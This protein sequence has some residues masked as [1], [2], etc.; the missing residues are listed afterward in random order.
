MKIIATGGWRHGKGTPNSVMGNHLAGGQGDG[1]EFG[2]CNRTN[3]EGNRP[4]QKNIIL[5]DHQA[6]LNQARLFC[7]ANNFGKA[8]A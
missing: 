3:A 7:D 6:A 1:R 5:F 4:S 2:G 8:L